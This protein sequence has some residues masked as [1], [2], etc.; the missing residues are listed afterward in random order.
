MLISY[1]KGTPRGGGGG[2]GGDEGGVTPPPLL[3]TFLQF[4]GVLTKCV[5]KIS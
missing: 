4:V 1:T 2:E 5:G 3:P